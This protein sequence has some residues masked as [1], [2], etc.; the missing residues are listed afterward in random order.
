MT[1]LFFSPDHTL[2]ALVPLPGTGDGAKPM[3]NMQPGKTLL[4][5]AGDP[6][7]ITIFWFVPLWNHE[8]VR[9]RR[10]GAIHHSLIRKGG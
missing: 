4:I 10:M 9:K 3:R 6:S 8:L 7:D 1:D 2:D 5:I